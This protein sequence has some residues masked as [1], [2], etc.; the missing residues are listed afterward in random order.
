MS[1]NL[2]DKAVEIHGNKYVQVKDRLIKFNEDYPNGSIH[3]NI[4]E[5]TDDKVVVKAEVIPDLERPA[6]YFTGLAEEIRGSSNIN[7]TSALENCST[8]AVG[9]ALAMMGIGII[10]SV[11]SANEVKNAKEKQKTKKKKQKVK[12]SQK[13]S[14]TEDK[15]EGVIYTKEGKIEG[16]DK[17]KEGDNWTLWNVIIDGEKF[18]SFENWSDHI[19]IEE[20]WEYQ[21]NPDYDSNKLLPLKE[22]AISQK[23]TEE[24]AAEAVE[25]SEKK[26]AQAEINS[27]EGEVPFE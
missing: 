10:D 2:E 24:A 14:K 18:T 16:V 1:N 7:K 15:Q 5:N 6:R 3:T 25:K 26:K 22:Q 9:R 17:V 11:A 12:K 19:G 21:Y 20:E 13:K 23:S 4:I 8:S 27:Q